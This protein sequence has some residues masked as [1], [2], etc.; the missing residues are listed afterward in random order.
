MDAKDY[1]EVIKLVC[2]QLHID[3]P[4]NTLIRNI[5][6][7]CKNLNQIRLRERHPINTERYAAMAMAYIKSIQKDEPFD[8]NYYLQKKNAPTKETATLL[9]NAKQT[10]EPL[11]NWV[12]ERMPVISSK[13]MSV[14]LDSRVR[15]TSNDYN[16]TTITDFGFTLV[17]RQT[18]AELGDGRIQVRVMPSQITY[19]KIGKIILPY[20]NNMRLRNYMSEMTLTFTALRS[21][22]IIA[23]E[24][25]YHFTF[26][27]QVNQ[28][29]NALIE[30]TPTNEYCKSNPPLRVI[31]DLSIRFNDPIY[32][33][34]F[35]I[36]RMQPAQINYLSSD[37][38]IIFDNPHKL[39]A[40]DVI[41]V[42]GL[43]T[44][45]DAS[46]ANILNQINDPKGLVVT[47]INANIVS[48]GIDFSQIVSA[49]LNAKPW[50][51]FYS[52]TFRF[53]LEIG[54]QD[55]SEL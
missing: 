15:N 22:G 9:A 24:D 14:Y 28:T 8:Y 50:I 34:A 53:P 5:T 17:P 42:L 18:R 27:Y 55:I 23:R 21:N 16:K 44:N 35:P 6:L 29:N 54:Y 39:D 1:A 19:F 31:D 33:V 41:I 3:T 30:L 25:T 46:N 13:A 52:Q 43:T 37:G 2:A 12:S 40:N 32:P 11:T 20:D 45:D 7:Y 36:D 26:T 38:R 4:D 10:V 51:L 49:D 47:I 48:T